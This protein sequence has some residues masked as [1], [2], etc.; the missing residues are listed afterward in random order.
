MSDY[1]DSWLASIARAAPFADRNWVRGAGQLK[2]SW[3]IELRYLNLI[4][5]GYVSEAR[6]LAD[7]WLANQRNQYRAERQST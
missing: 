7:Q 4:T 1:P 3:I 6:S 2:P 5:S